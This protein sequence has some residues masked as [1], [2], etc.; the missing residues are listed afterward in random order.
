SG[1]G[2]ERRECVVVHDSRDPEIE[3]LRLAALIYQNVAG[4]QVAMDNAAHVSVVN[5]FRNEG[6]QFQTLPRVQF[7]RIAVVLEGLAANEFQGEMGRRADPRMGGARLKDLRDSGVVQ[8]PERMRLL[9]K[10]AHQFRAGKAGI[11]NLERYGAA[12]I[13]LLGFIDG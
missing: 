13:A 11:E 4:L 8:A 5:G 10:P 12:W 2:L 7:M 3:N 9:L 6:H 1:I